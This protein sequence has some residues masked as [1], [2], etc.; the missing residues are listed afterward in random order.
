MFKTNIRL[1]NNIKSIFE[2]SKNEFSEII[3]FID[4]NMFKV[5][6]PDYSKYFIL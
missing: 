1:S 3:S 5:N 4:Y 2:K 6:I